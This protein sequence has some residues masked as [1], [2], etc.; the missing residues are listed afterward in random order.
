[1]PI[2]IGI[3]KQI[4]YKQETTWGTLAGATGGKLLRRVTANFNLE[5]ET[6]QSGEIR[7]DYQIADMRHGV[8]TVAGSLSG[9]LSPGTYADFMGAVVAR[10]FTAGVSAT[11]LTLTTAG[12]GPTYTLTRSAGSWLT[13][14]FK[15]GDVVRITA[16][17]VNANNLNKNLVV[18]SMTATVLTVLV[19]NGTTVTAESNI[20]SV[21]VTVFGKKTF[22]PTSGHTDRSFTVEE[23]YSDIAQSEVFTGM[24]VNTMGLSL[25][26]TGLVTCDFG[27]MGKDMT[28]TGVTQ[29][30]TTPAAQSTTGIFAAVNGVLVVNGSPVA[31]LTNLSLNVNRNMQNATVVGSNSVVEMFEG[32]VA[33]EGDFSAYFET[34][35]FR[36]LFKDETE[37]SLI[38]TLSAS[39]AK[40]ADF[41][42]ITLPRIKVN[43]NTRDD[44]ENGISAQ[45]SFMALL[46][47][48]GGTGLS[49]E[50]T[51]ISI[52]D[53]AA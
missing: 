2:A 21:T 17:A 42:S 7:T 48:A 6:Y 33:V 19:L 32:R 53:S 28:Q 1:M 43:T 37:A 15:I 46:N 13:D 5:K 35:A 47:G 11:G 18:V 4:A 16:G 29:Y 20:A 49:T 23:W 14:G 52:Q 3:A 12:S 24:K 45:H 51:T 9:E 8:R 22:A 30:F 36:D 25:P 34:G 26:A 31:L 38:V 50:R 44:G 39:S 41:V 10:D 40:D 27:F